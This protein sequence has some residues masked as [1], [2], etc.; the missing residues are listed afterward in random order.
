MGS[1]GMTPFT[2]P[3]SHHLVVHG[4]GQVHAAVDADALEDDLDLRV[5]AGL[6]G[7]EQLGDVDVVALVPRLREQQSHDNPLLRWRCPS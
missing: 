7:V 5:D 2:P 1:Y 3:A 6:A 4:L